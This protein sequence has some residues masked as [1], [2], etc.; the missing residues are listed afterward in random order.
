MNKNKILILT[1]DPVNKNYTPMTCP[2]QFDLLFSLLIDVTG[3]YNFAEWMDPSNQYVFQCRTALT[4]LVK[5]NKNITIYSIIDLDE[6]QPGKT[7]KK[8]VLSHAKF[9]ETIIKWESLLKELPAK[10]YVTSDQDGNINLSRHVSDELDYQQNDCT[11]A[12]KKALGAHTEK[13]KINSRLQERVKELKLNKKT[14]DFKV[15]QLTFFP[16]EWTQEIGYKKINEA[17]QACHTEIIIKNR[18]GKVIRRT[19]LGKTTENM[20]LHVI[21]NDN[22]DIIKTYPSATINF[23]NNAKD[24]E[25]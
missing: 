10:V 2:C 19:V 24:L 8:L 1:Q 17:L 16:K 7:T 3:P 6:Y 25:L 14:E 11:C 22:L 18:F 9:M 15:N 12:T 13:L 20:E 21:M 23:Y 4:L 5:D